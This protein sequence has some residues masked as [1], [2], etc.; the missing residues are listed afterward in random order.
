[1][2]TA[3]ATSNILHLYD[4][5]AY[6]GDHD[7]LLLVLSFIIYWYVFLVFYSSKRTLSSLRFLSARKKKVVGCPVVRMSG[8]DTTKTRTAHFFEPNA[9]GAKSCPIAHFIGS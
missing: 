2:P 5:V 1:M 7:Y 8:Y 3:L 9:R 4:T 6:L